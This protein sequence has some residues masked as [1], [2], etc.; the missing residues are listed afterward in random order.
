MKTKQGKIYIQKC[1]YASIHPSTTLIRIKLQLIE[2]DGLG[3]FYADINLSHLFV[4]QLID[5]SSGH[6][7]FIILVFKAFIT[8]LRGHFALSRLCGETDQHDG[9]AAGG[10]CFCSHGDLLMSDHQADWVKSPAKMLQQSSQNL[11]WVHWNWSVK[12]ELMCFNHQK[13]EVFPASM[14][15]PTNYIHILS[16]GNVLQWQLVLVLMAKN[17]KCRWF[18]LHCLQCKS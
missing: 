2:N 16:T 7:A 8:W 15:F 18:S 12:T 3:R 6:A 9:R 4:V 14:T 1:M 13:L 11:R 5:S 17:G 10:A